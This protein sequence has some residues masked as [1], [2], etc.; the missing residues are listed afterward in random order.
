MNPDLEAHQ[1]CHQKLAKHSINDINQ[2][3]SITPTWKKWKGKQKKA[4]TPAKKRALA[5]VHG[6]QDASAQ[7]DT[8]GK[9]DTAPQIH[10]QEPSREVHAAEVEDGSVANVRQAAE[11]LVLEGLVDGLV[12]IAVADV[13]CD[14]AGSGVGHLV[15]LT[16]QILALLVGSLGGCGQGG[17]L[18][19]DL[20]Q[21]LVQL[22]EVQ[23]AAAVLVVLVEELVKAA[24]VVGRLREALLDAR[25]HL[26][27]LAEG[28]L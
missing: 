24:Q 11:V 22:S 8:L 18:V 1:V 21:Q 5:P 3:I 7:T 15:E 23:G 13:V 19:V 28:N 4:L 26:A 17:N 12:D 16:A 9:V 6:Q 20:A 27:P 2:S 25:G 14:Q 10:G